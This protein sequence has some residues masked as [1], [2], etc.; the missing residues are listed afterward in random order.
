M[1][2]GLKLVPTPDLNDKP[3]ALGE[4]TPD[5]REPAR[6]TANSTTTPASQAQS[7][8]AGEAEV[9]PSNLQKMQFAQPGERTEG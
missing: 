4:W 2:I 8:N 5:G 6:L 3:I 7:G 1:V 9:T